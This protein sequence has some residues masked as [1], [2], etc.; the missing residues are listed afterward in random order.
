MPDYVYVAKG[1]S[2]RKV[3]VRTSPTTKRV[4]GTVKATYRLR[5]IKRSLTRTITPCYPTAV[6]SS[7]TLPT[8]VHAGSST[9][10]TVTL[11]CYAKT[12][13]AVS[14]T[15][16]NSGVTVPA[17]VTVP[18]GKRTASFKLGSK[19]PA[20]GSQAAYNA[21]IRATRGQKTASRTIQVR[22][23]L[24]TVSAKQ[25]SDSNAVDLTIGLS[26]PATTDTTVSLV[27][28]TGYI[29][30]V[31]VS[32]NSLVL[33]SK[34]TVPAGRSSLVVKPQLNLLPDD[35]TVTIKA[36]LAGR[37]ISTQLTTLRAFRAGDSVMHNEPTLAPHGANGDVTGEL[38]LI[39]D[40]PAGPEGAI[41]EFR[42]HQ[43]HIPAGSTTARVP[44]YAN[45]YPADSRISG[46]LAIHTGSGDV[47]EDVSYAVHP[48]PTGLR[49][50]SPVITGRP[51]TATVILAGASSQDETVQLTG[52]GVEVPA[53]VTVP[54]G[55]ASATFEIDGSGAGTGSVRAELRGATTSTTVTVGPAIPD[56]C[57]PQAID[58]AEDVY[59]TNDFYDPLAY[60]AQVTLGCAA[61]TD[62][63]IP[64]RSSDSYTLAV[65]RYVEVAAG[66]TTGAFT[67]K[68]I[69]GGAC[70]YFRCV[71]ER[72]VAVE[73]G[74]SGLSMSRM[75]A[76]KPGLWSSFF[77][78][79]AETGLR[80]VQIWMTGQASAG[81]V[82]SI[83]TDR[84]D[85]LAFPASVEV[86]AG[87]RYVTV[88]A[89]SIDPSA[90]GTTVHVTVTIG[91]GSQTY[92]LVLGQ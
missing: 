40:H 86:P 90:A 67:L 68:A 5:V 88:P 49:V 76:V 31:P 22:P 8:Y 84:P 55:A 52:A 53:T 60:Q 42:S 78:K 65:P 77:P 2:T 12:S 85:L 57:R 25:A 44:V 66:S 79:N 69:G 10:G 45:G 64:L 80:D 41:V 14:L 36:T 71:P 16:S 1:T 20:T 91:R 29:D 74:P 39:L 4:A 37:A 48:A 7:I 51:A 9:T 11:D 38:R 87:A 83:T 34:V 21:T 73:A 30:G 63:L 23:G 89:I 56:E 19:L 61:P 62:L 17:T 13:L 6:P 27:T 59:V 32:S 75:I 18:T 81:T 35:E 58:V 82:A 24:R 28:A 47:Y 50:P 43:A 70:Y 46:T 72:A 15:S 92:D 54:A 26:G 33:P 3:T